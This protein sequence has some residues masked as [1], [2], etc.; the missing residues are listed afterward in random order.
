M[1]TVTPVDNVQQRLIK[2]LSY[3]TGAISEK[4]KIN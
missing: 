4:I 1:L 3:T 2:T